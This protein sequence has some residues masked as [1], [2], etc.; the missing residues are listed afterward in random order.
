MIDSTLIAWHVQVDF[1]VS[2]LAKINLIISWSVILINNSDSK[3]L[4]DKHAVLKM[5]VA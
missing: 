1:L 2:K 3:W 5:I 4:S